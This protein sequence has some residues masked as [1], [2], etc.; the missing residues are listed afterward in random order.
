MQQQQQ[1]HASAG[2]GLALAVLRRGQGAEGGVAWGGG[3]RG[4]GRQTALP[5]DPPAP[6]SALQALQLLWPLVVTCD[7]HSSVQ[8]LLHSWARGH[9]YSTSCSYFW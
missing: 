5:R 7:A 4:Q 1:Q 2:L 3:L 6:A 9:N 8:L